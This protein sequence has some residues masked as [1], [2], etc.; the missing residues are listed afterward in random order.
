MKIVSLLGILL[1]FLIALGDEVEKQYDELFKN[2]EYYNY[3]R[4]K[5]M[6]LNV[7]WIGRNTNEND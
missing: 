2:G 6:A 1:I 5:I 7:K 4:E 3:Q